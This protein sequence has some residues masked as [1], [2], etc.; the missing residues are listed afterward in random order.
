MEPIIASPR[1]APL[2]A[3]AAANGTPSIAPECTNAS[4]STSAPLPP[5]DGLCQ[6]CA[7]VPYQFHHF[8]AFVCNRCRAFFRRSVR[9]GRKGPA[10]TD[11]LTTGDPYAD[12][13]TPVCDITLFRGA[14]QVRW[15][16]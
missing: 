10:V 11:C 4:S 9:R 3:A 14:C 12:G 8:G 16:F 7:V 15:S 2:A 1:D 6:V 5:A 13:F